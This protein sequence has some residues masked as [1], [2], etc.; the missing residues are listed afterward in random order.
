MA[1]VDFHYPVGRTV[2]HLDV[3]PLIEAL[4]FQPEDF[5][6]SYGWL[7]HAPSRHRFRFD[8]LGQVTVD[9]N[10]G[11][12]SMNV[13]PEQSSEL[14]ASYRTWRREYW[15]P[16]ETNREFASHFKKPN[17]WVRLARDIRMAFRRFLRRDKATGLLVDD[18]ADAQRDTR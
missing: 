15:L 16:I 9:A 14:F 4:R 17:A 5:D 2:R 10:C 1:N 18:L 12:A 13:K 3:S 6:I 7:N 8:P 11:C